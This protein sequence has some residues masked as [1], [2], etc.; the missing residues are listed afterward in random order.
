MSASLLLSLAEI[1]QKV[2]DVTSEQLGLR[3]SQVHPALRLL[4]DLHCDSLDAVELLM[5]IEDQFDV[6]LPDDSNN[7]AYKALFTRED[8]RLSDLAEL[9]YLQQGT[10]RQRRRGFASRKDAAIETKTIPFTQLG[11]RLATSELFASPLF[12]SIGDNSEGY[13][14]YRRRTDGMICV[15]LPGGT[16]PLGSDAA[17]TLPDESPLHEV[18][19]DPFLI[20]QEPV[21]TTAY[22]RFLNSIGSVDRPTLE[23]WFILSPDDK[24]QQHE[25]LFHG[26]DGW[27]PKPGTERMPMMLV[28]WFGADA[29]SKWANR[30][31]WHDRTSPGFLPSE[32]QWEYAAR[33]T[34]SRR[35]PW[36]DEEPTADRA[37]C[38]VHIRGRTYRPEELPMADVNVD[39]GT[40]TFGLRHMAGNVWQWCRDWY[41]PN[42]YSSPAAS[43]PNSVNEQ[44]TQIR[45]ERGGSWVGPGFL[46]RC[47][48]RRGRAP[49][50]KGRC[51]GFR[52]V[53]STL[54]MRNAS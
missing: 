23:E 17:D 10:V 47:S 7:M 40:S 54:D 4:D 26:P 53:S 41:D 3:R 20:D 9:V 45:S 35:Y 36:G 50:A 30:R 33:G 37:R 31:D 5:E 27:H 21:S 48:Y 12:E 22:C 8:F 46:C 6:A 49:G 16:V 13:R 29:Y 32:A 15:K 11:G 19:L 1:E 28:S 51:L 44:P 43:M 24:R 25:P 42:F 39:L 18:H 38:A 34:S 2:C 52:C 14:S